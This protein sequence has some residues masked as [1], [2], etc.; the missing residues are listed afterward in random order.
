MRLPVPVQNLDLADIKVRQQELI[1]T[2]SHP[3]VYA[4]HPQDWAEMARMHEGAHVAASEALGIPV[5][6][7]WVNP[8]QAVAEGGQYNNGPGDSQ[9]QCVVYA[10]G[11]EGGAQHLR[12][13]GYP[14]DLVEFSVKAL[15]YSDRVITERVAAEAADQGFQLDL[16]RAQSDALSVLYSDGFL[17]AARSVAQALADQG[18]RLTGADVRAA[19]GGWQLDR[20]LWVPASYELP[21]LILTR[22]DPDEMEIEL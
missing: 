18:D 14:E 1:V 15:G 13:A 9:L 7:V 20:N 6:D 4:I 19:M 2:K 10:I 16:R 17:G 22:E 12:E 11:A 8:N 21:E 5:V 3:W